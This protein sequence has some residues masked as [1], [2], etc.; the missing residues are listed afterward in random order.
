MPA[1]RSTPKST[2]GRG[3]CPEINTIGYCIRI[4][5][6][7][8]W[9]EDASASVNMEQGPESGRKDMHIG[10]EP[11][12]WEKDWERSSVIGKRMASI[13][14]VPPREHPNRPFHI[15]R[16][17]ESSTNVFVRCQTAGSQLQPRYR[18]PFKVLTKR[19]KYFILDINGKR[20][21][22][23]LDRLKPAFLES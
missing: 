20:E 22:I 8:T 13:R 14:P 6:M 17:L 11:L 16:N 1:P 4:I 19:R 15:D 21:T 5:S 9:P 12:S 18:G 23:S 10:D 3:L 2:Y 7:L